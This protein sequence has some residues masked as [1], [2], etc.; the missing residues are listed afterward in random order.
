MFIIDW[1]LDKFGYVNK[2]SIVFSIN[3]PITKKPAKK[4]VAKK[5][6]RRLG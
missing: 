1:V 5:S 3:K 4:T 6:K 2:A